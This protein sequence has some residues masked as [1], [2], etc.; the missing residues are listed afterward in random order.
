MTEGKIYLAVNND[1]VID[2]RVHRTAVTLM[3]SGM[4]PVLVG[5]KHWGSPPL[6]ERPYK[7]LR[8][9]ILFRKG[10]LLYACFNLRL[11]FFLLFRRMQILVSNDLDTLPACHL[12]SRLKGVKLVYDSHEFFSELPELI[13]RPFVRGVWRG[14]EKRLFPRI[15][16]SYTVCDSIAGE[17]GKRYGVEM[18]VVRNLPVMKVHQAAHP[19]LPDVD[20]QRII[21]YQGALNVGRGLEGMIRAM[22]YLENF[23][24]R[25][26]GT[27][28]MEKKLKG[29][30]QDMKLGDRVSFMGRIP[31]EELGIHTRQ[32]SLGI[33]L[34]ENLG[35]NYYYALPNKLFDY[36]QEQIPVL[37]SDLP[38]MKAIVE[39]Y[40]VGEVVISHEPAALAKQIRRMTENHEQRNAWKKNL[41]TAA[42]ELCWEKEAD[43]L[44]EVYV[45]AGLTF[46]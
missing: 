34:E 15:Q 2:Q 40:G 30:V 16:Y 1:L 19:D 13:G 28:P 38:E 31:F 8:M 14:L 6:R 18:A 46:P 39:N 37:V 27:G 7:I 41:Q 5:R 23:F 12:V 43:R 17:Y 35:L 21:I 20:P 24:S 44:K 4:Q 45:N 33:S 42:G 29:M 3:E 32:A 26:F 11:F 25:I 10:F 22:E 9:S 36:I